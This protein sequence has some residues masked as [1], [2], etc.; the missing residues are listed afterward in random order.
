MFLI[1]DDGYTRL[2]W[3]VGHK[4]GGTVHHASFT[5]YSGVGTARSL[6]SNRR[7]AS[8]EERDAALS[9]FVEDKLSMG[10]RKLPAS[11]F[12]T[13]MQGPQ[14]HPPSRLYSER[15]RQLLRDVEDEQTWR[16]YADEDRIEEPT[17]ASDTPVALRLAMEPYR[18]AHSYGEARTLAPLLQGEWRHGFILDASLSIESRLSDSVQDVEILRALAGWNG[19]KFLR[20]LTLGRVIHAG[21]SGDRSFDR[22]LDALVFYAPR[23]P[24]RELNVV[25]SSRCMDR[26]GGYSD[27]DGSSWTRCPQNIGRLLSAFA[28][29]RVLSVDATI[30]KMA[31]LRH[32]TLDTLRIRCGV[33]S[34]DNAQALASAELP[35]LARLELSFCHR[36]GFVQGEAR[37]IRTLLEGNAFPKL[38]YLALQNA[39]HLNEIAE[40]V[41]ASAILPSLSH[42]DLSGGGLDDQGGELLLQQEE[43]LRHL[44]TLDVR[45]NHL[46][47]S[48]VEALRQTFGDTIMLDEQSAP[49]PE[50]EFDD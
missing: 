21:W 24:L 11:S 48:V 17:H 18:H 34:D 37:Q 38:E 42:L 22:I 14:V 1:H 20:S 9:K 25:G 31:H 4:S 15:E 39:L 16:D 13:T 8:A 30:I 33:F 29:L 41:V 6:T 44:K 28:D 7:F 47:P 12:S 27:N 36:E 43:A 19:A 45:R 35:R 5:F 23:F 32:K 49:L 10:Y 46:S 26:D 40:V 50:P 3:K 2:G